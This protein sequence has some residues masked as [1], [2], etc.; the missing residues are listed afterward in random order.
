VSDRYQYPDFVLF[1]ILIIIFTAH[2]LGT[3]F[4]S[5]L[6]AV[7]AAVGM[8]YVLIMDGMFWHGPVD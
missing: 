2:V 4:D 3:A 8:C 6:V 1:I 7:M 5:R